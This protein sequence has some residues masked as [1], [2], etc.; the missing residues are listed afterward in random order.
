VYEGRHC[1]GKKKVLREADFVG[2]R[3][4]TGWDAC[5]ETWDDG[6][7]MSYKRLAHPNL[8]TWLGSYEVQGGFT[9][10]TSNRCHD[11]FH[12]P[13]K[14]VEDYGTTAVDGCREIDYDFNYVEIVH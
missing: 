13:D 9:I 6:S 3:F 7:D 10:S 12:Y 8:H 4:S 14:V 5:G 2:G 1:S 11:D